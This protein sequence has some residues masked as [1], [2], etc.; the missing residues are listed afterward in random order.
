MAHFYTVIKREKCITGHNSSLQIKIK[1]TC[2][3]QCMPQCINT[4]CLS[5]TFPN[6]LFV[7]NQCNGVRLEVFANDICKNKVFLFSFVC[8]PGSRFFPLFKI[9]NV[10]ALFQQT[11]YNSFGDVCGNRTLFETQQN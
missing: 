8:W 5:A 1:M 9:S 10:L 6:K 4:T 2:F 3:F 11:I 7:L